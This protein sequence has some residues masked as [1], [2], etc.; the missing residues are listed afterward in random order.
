MVLL[1]KSSGLLKQFMTVF[2]LSSSLSTLFTDFDQALNTRIVQGI[3]VVCNSIPG[4]VMND[5]LS[6]G[7][8]VR[9]INE[10]MS[11]TKITL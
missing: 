11:C 5:P 1:H 9:L 10:M 2:L 8:K 6:N 4:M 3:L 7:S